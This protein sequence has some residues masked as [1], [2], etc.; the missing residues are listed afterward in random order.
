MNVVLKDV[1]CT[2]SDAETFT[3]LPLIFLRG[4]MTKYVHGC[5][6]VDTLPTNRDCTHRYVQ[7]AEQMMEQ[8]I[9]RLNEIEHEKEIARSEYNKFGDKKHNQQRNT[10]GGKS[11]NSKNPSK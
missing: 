11:A 10:S 2:S 3:K 7:V 6:W 9:E 1:V 4:N 5:A 8:V